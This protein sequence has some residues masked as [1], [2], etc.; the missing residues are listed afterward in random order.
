MLSIL[1][2]RKEARKARRSLTLTRSL[3]H[4]TLPHQWATEISTPFFT[5][6]SSNPLMLIRHLHI[7]LVTPSPSLHA[8]L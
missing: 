1:Q 5:R 3:F 7:L 2:T 4:F 8:G 6:V